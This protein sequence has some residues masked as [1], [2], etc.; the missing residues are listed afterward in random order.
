MPRF[1]FHTRHE[2][3]LIPD[4]EGLEFATVEL[5]RHAALAGVADRIHDAAHA[6]KVFPAE[7]LVVTDEYGNEIA[8]FSVFESLGIGVPDNI[9]WTE[10]YAQ[11][12]EISR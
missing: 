3:R 12:T 6:N 4:T 9:L 2:A 5:A 10:H 7:E 11:M 8:V 1:F